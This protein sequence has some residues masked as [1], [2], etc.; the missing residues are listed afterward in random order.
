MIGEDIMNWLSHLTSGVEEIWLI[1][2]IS[3]AVVLKMS[4]SAL[5]RWRRPRWKHL[6][7]GEEGVSYTLSYLLVFPFFFLFVCVVFEATWLLAAKIGTMYTAHAGARSAVVWASAQPTNL[8][9]TRINQ[10]VWTAMT[11]FVTGD[12]DWLKVP[13]EA[14]EQSGEY[15][16]AYE[17]CV[18]GN[19]DPNAKPATSTLANRY[20]T[21]ASRTTWQMKIDKS[22]PDGDVTVTV[23]Y[24]A[25]LHIP[26]AA[27]VLNPNGW[28]RNEY[29]I[30]STATLPNEAPASAD[31]TLGID[32]QSR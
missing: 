11:P 12:P 9:K 10:S 2:L 14:F 4:A 16:L 20:L 32:Y 18:G 31:G 7:H 28:P 21:A 22:K 5:R 25:P 6:A 13:G 1:W 27:R 24:R 15:V 17:L 19:D 26:G 8:Q 23:T 29:A 30:T 3:L